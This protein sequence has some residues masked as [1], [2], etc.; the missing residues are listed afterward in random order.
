MEDLIK[1]S[2][3]LEMV[4]DWNEDEE[5]KLTYA[6]FIELLGISPE[7]IEDDTEGAIT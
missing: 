3:L 4:S 2:M 1:K 5:D 6:D 7:Q